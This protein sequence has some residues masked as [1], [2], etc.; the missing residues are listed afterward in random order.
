MKRLIALFV[1][2][3]TACTTPAGQS[4]GTGPGP[5][6]APAASQAW[7]NGAVVYE[8]FVRSFKDSDGDGRGDLAGLIEKLDYLNDGDPTTDSDLGVDAIWLMPI[9]PSPSYHGYDVTDYDAVNPEYGTLSDLDR[10]VTECHRR[11]VKVVLDFVPNH[12]SSQHPWF[13]DAVSSPAALHRDWYVWS[14][15]D[16][17]W[18]QP[19]GAGRTWF[20]AGGAY[21]YA[22]FWS[23]MPDLN[24][25]NDAVRSEL[26][27][28]AA[29]WLARGVDGLR[30]DAV[31]Y[32]VENGA[33]L[34]QD[35]PETHRALRDLASAARATAPD[36]MLVGEAWADTATIATYFG[37][38]AGSHPEGDEL[39]LTFDFPLADAVVRSIATGDGTAAAKAL[40][41]IA[42]A[43]PAGAGD[44][45][46]LTNH[47]QVRVATQLGGDGRRLRLAAAILL[48][49][50]GTPFIYYGEEIG[51]R[52]GACSSDECKRTPMAWDA[53]GARGFTAGTPWFA[54]APHF[55]GE[56]VAAAAPDPASLLSRYRQ[57]IRVRKSSP[58]LSRGGTRRLGT[59]SRSTLALVRSDAAENVLVVHNL[60]AGTVTERLT[61]DGATADAL[62]TDPGVTLVRDGAAWA[63]TVPP[64]ASGVWRLR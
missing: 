46:F 12:T 4:G 50:Q 30:L 28:A 38:T 49:L 23:G 26:S 57:L 60:G 9:Y 45:P 56:D 3:A 36:A 14:A 13:L 39:P 31:R 8:V 44:A 25:R 52:N 53:T 16:E 51:M 61:A 15:T 58:A 33:G 54:P 64:Y 55:T 63:A 7:W 19:F 48:T 2:I 29:R 22:V 18:T 6:R 21:Y 17:G 40:D 62:F 59:A 37:S 1:L 34:Q 47:D 27:A 24:W 5:A 42:T 20:P 41:A 43:Y 35:Q 32:L 10:L 11:G